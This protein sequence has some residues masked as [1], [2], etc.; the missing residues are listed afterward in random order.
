MYNNFFVYPT[1][2]ADFAF[3]LGLL[4]SQ[5]AFTSSIFRQGFIGFFHT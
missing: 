5:K 2:R 3:F 4:L 1:R